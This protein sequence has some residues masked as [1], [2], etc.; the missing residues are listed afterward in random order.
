MAHNLEFDNSGAMMTWAKTGGVPWHG[1]GVPV[2]DDLTP[3]QMMEAARLDWTVDMIPAFAEVNGQRI[4]VGHSALVRSTDGKVLDVVTND[5]NPTQNSEAFEFFNDFIAA[6][7]MSMETAGSLKGGTIIWA[8]AKIKDGFTLFGGKDQIDSYLLFVNP[9]QYGSSIVVKHTPTR[10]VCNNTLSI[11]LN[12]KTQHQVRQSHRRKFDGTE[13]KM[14][15]GIAHDQL[16]AYKEAAEYLSQ[17]R[18]KDE[19]VV[20]YFRRVF[21][22]VTKDEEKKAEKLSRPAQLA[23]SVMDEQPGAEMGEGTYWQM[24][25]AT[26]FA[27][28]HLLGRSRDSGLTSAWLGQ[29]SRIKNTALKVALEM[30]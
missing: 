10:V 1:L 17:K 26:T 25:N 28:D 30:A 21:P 4:D 13:A 18:F 12:E 11:S 23:M 3:Q 7:D 2:S 14:Q 6:G 20:E 5:W 22:M 24:L 9:H 16:M 8:L 27:V 29:G 19:D 15:L